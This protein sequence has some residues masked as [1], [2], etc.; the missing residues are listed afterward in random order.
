VDRHRVLA[1]RRPGLVLLGAALAA[2]ALAVAGCGGGGGG[3]TTT[4]SST[5]TGSDEDAAR[6]P[7]QSSVGYGGPAP[8][9]APRVRAAAAAAGCTV[10]GF[11]FEPVAV[12]SDG[13]YHT[14]GNP[15]YK[16]SLP[17]TSGL[18]NPVWAD[19]GVYD[20]PVPFKFQVHNLEHG[21]IVVHLGSRLPASARDAVVDLWRQSPPFMLV[22]PETFAQF[23][24]KAIVV[25]SWQRWMV[26]N[27]YTPKALAAI[28]VYRDVYRGTGP[29]AAG[30][31]N[32]GT[33]ADGLP[34]PAIPDEGAS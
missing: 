29:E 8:A 22:T 2:G 28:R 25:T 4:G 21:G 30:A 17:P 26:C 13:S 3:A 34:K 9:I 12:Q 16:V 33:T 20:T 15:Q 32:S 11:P 24:P 5:G 6:F 10:R 27:P 19:W 7:R 1:S 23:P 14:E 18:H 31:L